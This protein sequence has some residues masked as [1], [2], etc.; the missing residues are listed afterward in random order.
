MASS[1]GTIIVLLVIFLQ[2]SLTAAV[3]LNLSPLLSPFLEDVCKEIGCGKG[4]CVASMSSTNDLLHPFKCECEPGWKQTIGGGNNTDHDFLQFL[5][6][7]IPNCT[8]DYS[9][10][11]AAEPPMPQ[12]REPP[13]NESLFDPCNWAYC[14][15][16]SCIKSNAFGHKCECMEGYENLLNVTAFPC[17]RECAIG[18]DCLKLGIAAPNRTTNST[19]NMPDRSGNH[20][21][22]IL[23]GKFLSLV[24]FVVTIMMVPWK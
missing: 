8:M 9:C 14:G 4:K 17:L 22:T 13:S 10:N 21:S 23:Q 18:M 12:L 11:A 1:N 2:S 15:H 7:V 24:I 5:P 19:P 20:A 16:G 6:C 3:D